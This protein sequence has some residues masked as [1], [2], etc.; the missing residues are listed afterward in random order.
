[1]EKIKCWSWNANYTEKVF[2][3]S[4]E[5]HCDSCLDDKDEGYGDDIMGC[6]CI[7]IIEYK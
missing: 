6:C 7:H 3:E 4:E 1:M 2:F 5:Y